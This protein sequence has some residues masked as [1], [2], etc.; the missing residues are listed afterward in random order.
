[1]LCEFLSCSLTQLAIF[2]MILCY[3]IKWWLAEQAKWDLKNLQLKWNSVGKDIVVLHQFSRAR[4]CPS[5][6]PFPIKLE[7]FLRVHKIKYITDF[8]TPFSEKQKSPWITINGKNIADSQI[9]IEYLTD[10]FDLEPNRGLTKTDLVIQR[11]LRFLIEQDLYAIWGH[12][13]WVKTEGKFV[14]EFFAPMF[15]I[16]PTFIESSIVAKLY[17]IKLTQQIYLQGMGRHKNEEI[18]AMG[19]DDI[20]SLA[21]FLGDK[22]FMFGL[23]HPTEIDFVLFGILVMFLY[24]TPKDNPHVQEIL[25]N[26]Q[27][28]VKFVDRMKSQY[29]PDWEE[30]CYKDPL[31]DEQ[32]KLIQ[33]TKSYVG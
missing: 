7:T 22:N 19:H 3:S 13:R 5:P 23:D 2:A 1:M 14:T 10:Y 20:K 15:P 26:H 24:A 25:K 4:Y 18:E 17:S 33:F 27:N 30:C 29:W 11:S 28:L 31:E 6:S 16:L 21:T 12:D 32:M 8:S 9:I